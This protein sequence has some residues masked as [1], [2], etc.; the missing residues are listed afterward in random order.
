MTK[1]VKCKC[2]CAK[3]AVKSTKKKTTKKTNKK[4][5]FWQK[6]KAFFSLV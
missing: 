1:T 2:G 5:T 6:V 4:L 3:K